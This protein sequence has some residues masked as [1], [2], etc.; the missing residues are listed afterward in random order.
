[1]LGGISNKVNTKSL[2]TKRLPNAGL[3]LCLGILQCKQ[4]VDLDPRS[5]HYTYAAHR[6]NSDQE[7]QENPFSQMIGSET[8][9]PEERV[10]ENMYAAAA[11]VR[12][13]TPPRSRASIQR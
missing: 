3:L 7:L 12:R 4:R 1:M 13:R 10:M 5:E 2:L 9:G 11:T 8:P 6:T